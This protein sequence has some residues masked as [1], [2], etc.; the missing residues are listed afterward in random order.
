[1]STFTKQHFEIF[2]E[3]VR[4]RVQPKY[5]IGTAKLLADV[6]GKSNTRFDKDSFIVACLP[7]TGE[8]DHAN[9]GRENGSREDAAT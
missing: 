2:A 9:K 4:N 3:V 1:M 8:K 5:R 6:F 7:A